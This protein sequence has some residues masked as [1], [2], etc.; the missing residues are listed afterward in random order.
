MDKH[1]AYGKP[2]VDMLPQHDFDELR[3]IRFSLTDSGREVLRLE[4]EIESL[5][6]KLAAVSPLVP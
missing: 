2:F 1:P 3:R 5:K 6:A 4:R